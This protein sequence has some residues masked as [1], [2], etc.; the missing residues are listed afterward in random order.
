MQNEQ[1]STK[2]DKLV[3][4]NDVVLFLKGSAEIPMCGFSGVVVTILNRLNLQ[5]VD[6]NILEDSELRQGIKDYSDWP[7]IPQL[8][9][10]G[11]F[12]GGCDIVRD[13]YEK[14]ELQE[15]LKRKELLC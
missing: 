14:G 1:I 4:N 3:K 5:F 10:K 11:D 7:T 12:I 15:L 8:Y 13:M 9:I 6:V 2:I